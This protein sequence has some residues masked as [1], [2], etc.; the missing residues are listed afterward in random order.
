MFDTTVPMDTCAFTRQGFGSNSGYGV[1]C[2][3]QNLINLRRYALAIY[4]F[5][6]L[7]QLAN[8]F[9]RVLEDFRYI[10]ETTD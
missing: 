4:Q 5:N 1:L 6:E 3:I 9:V 8:K 7:L 2:Q 10:G